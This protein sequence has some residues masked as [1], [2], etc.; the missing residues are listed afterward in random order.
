M[1]PLTRHSQREPIWSAEYSLRPIPHAQTPAQQLR[2]LERAAAAVPSDTPIWNAALAELRQGGVTDNDVG[3]GETLATLPHLKIAVV[4]PY[5]REDLGILKRCHESV[6][7]QTYPSRHIMVADGFPREEI[8]GWDAEHVRLEHNHSD[9]GDTPRAVG[10]ERALSFGCD[11]I[12]YLDADNSFRPRHLESMIRCCHTTSASV[13][14]SGRTLHFP[15]GLM[16]PE[17]DPED[18]RTHIDTSCLLLRGEARTMAS[19]WRVYPRQLARL[20]DRLVVRMLRAR[21]LAFACTGALTV[22]YT[23]NYAWMYRAL[24]LEVPPDARVDFD[25]TPIASYCSGLSAEESQGLDLL[26]GFPAGE[27]LRDFVKRYQEHRSTRTDSR[28]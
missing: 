2:A 3:T 6:L 23:V 8:D 5:F 14:F 21:G 28:V 16:L 10:G 12:A 19:A 9:Y 1:D 18:C 15:N 22:R 26:L 13:I 7:E 25:V 17:V 27:F 11:A 24:N 4:T 20:D